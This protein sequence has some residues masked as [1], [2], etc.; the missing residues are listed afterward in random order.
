MYSR[1]VFRG[2]QIISEIFEEKLLALGIGEAVRLEDEALQRTRHSSVLAFDSPISTHVNSS[3]CAH[4]DS[5][6]SSSTS[7]NL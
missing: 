6:S 3:A 5:S 2:A 7:R 1:Q 4:A